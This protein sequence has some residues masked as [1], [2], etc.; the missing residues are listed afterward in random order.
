LVAMA[1]T[2]LLTIV[3]TP[4]K[5]ENTH[6]GPVTTHN[7]QLPIRPRCLFELKE[8][9]V[10]PYPTSGAPLEA[11]GLPIVARLGPPREADKDCADPNG[12]KVVTRETDCVLLTPVSLLHVGKRHNVRF[13]RARLVALGRGR[14]R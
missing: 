14:N 6:T 13:V 1:T 12:V 3:D 10:R 8:R 9:R 11:V 4:L 5:L 2:A 7:V